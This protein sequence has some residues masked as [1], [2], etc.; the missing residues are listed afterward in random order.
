MAKLWNINKE[1]ADLVERA[2]SS[3]SAVHQVLDQVISRLDRQH[4][5]WACESDQKCCE[6][7]HTQSYGKDPE[8][9]AI[10][11]FHNVH[12]E[13][14]TDARSRDI[15]ESQCG[16]ASHRICLLYGFSTLFD[17]G[18]GELDL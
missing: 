11:S 7:H 10:W 16:Q 6:E 18:L 2:F 1:S 12:T 17:L 8:G 3:H 15:D 14:A 13:D 9:K 4:V 5:E